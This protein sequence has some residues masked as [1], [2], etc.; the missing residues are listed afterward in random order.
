MLFMLRYGGA[1][2]CR[3]YQEICSFRGKEHVK[4]SPYPLSR[5]T[6]LV[7]PIDNWAIRC[8]DDLHYVQK[9]RN[10]YWPVVHAKTTISCFGDM[11]LLPN[12]SMPV[13]FLNYTSRKARTRAHEIRPDL[14]EPMDA[15]VTWQHELFSTRPEALR[16]DL[17][18]SCQD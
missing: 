16:R 17:H 4:F 6:Y 15:P 13:V 2:S 9:D 1:E 11:G 8:F 10:M 7:A 5:H 14:T 18:K 12:V 3:L